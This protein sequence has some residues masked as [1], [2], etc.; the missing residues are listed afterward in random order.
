[1]ARIV[2]TA[3]SRNRRN[4]PVV[5]DERVLSIHLNDGHAADQLVERLGWAISDAEELERSGQ[6]SSLVTTAAR[7]GGSEEK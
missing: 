2:V 4:A 7:V 6:R 3:D 5:L 1:M